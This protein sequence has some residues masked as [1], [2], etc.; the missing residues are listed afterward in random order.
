MGSASAAPLNERRETAVPA[1]LGSERVG[2]TAQMHWKEIG[3]WQH[4]SDSL[5]AGWGPTR[6]DGTV[7]HGQHRLRAWPR[8]GATVSGR[9]LSTQLRRVVG[10]P[11]GRS[12]NS[13]ARSRQPTSLTR[14][15][16]GC[17]SPLSVPITPKSL[18]HMALPR[19]HC[20]DR[21]KGSGRLSQWC[22]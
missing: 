22:S 15:P 21:P 14:P 16:V 2:N 9:W 13:P 8:A 18:F 17:H 7:P 19:S 3:R 10:G 5:K 12:N 6:S 11:S 20:C 4:L 1:P